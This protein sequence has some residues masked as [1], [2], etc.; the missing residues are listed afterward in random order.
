MDGFIAQEGRVEVCVNGV[1][2]S[3]CSTGWS[4]DDANVVCRQLGFPGS[5]KSTSIMY[6]MLLTF[7]TGTFFSQNP[8]LTMILALEMDP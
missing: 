5:S 7:Y 3:V 4:T 2:G 6:I 1:W 8:Y